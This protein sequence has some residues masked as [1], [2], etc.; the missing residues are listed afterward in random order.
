MQNLQA[1]ERLSFSSNSVRILQQTTVVS[2]SIR[3][4]RQKE[5]SLSTTGQ[6]DGGK[7]THPFSGS[8]TA[9]VLVRRVKST[10]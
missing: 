9:C 6:A 10:M 8:S 2:D 3:W 1:H 5:V 4:Q 7:F